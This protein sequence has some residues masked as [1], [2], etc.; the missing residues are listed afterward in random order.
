M[1]QYLGLELLHNII[2]I[3]GYRIIIIIIIIIIV[4]PLL[5]VTTLG[6]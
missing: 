5:L 2:F 1:S 4:I 6:Q 3:V